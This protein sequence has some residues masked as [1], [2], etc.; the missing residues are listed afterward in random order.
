MRAQGGKAVGQNRADSLLQVGSPV[1][2]RRTLRRGARR[3]CLLPYRYSHPWLAS[4][5]CCATY[6]IPLRETPMSLRIRSSSRSNSA[7]A[8]RCR[9]PLPVL[10]ARKAY[11]FVSQ[12]QMP[13]L[14]SLSKRVLGTP[15][16]C[17]IG[18]LIS[19]SLFGWDFVHALGATSGE[20]LHPPHPSIG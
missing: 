9:C 6:G 8:R 20:G 14:I 7:I 13:T 1:P 4:R 15:A 18:V 17:K 11:K 16:F 5:P 19:I 12:G 3:G 2:G 10:G